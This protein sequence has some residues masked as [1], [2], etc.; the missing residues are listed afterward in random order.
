VVYYIWYLARTSSML[1]TDIQS[2]AHMAAISK[3]SVNGFNPI[4][5]NMYAFS[6]AKG[7]LFQR[8]DNLILE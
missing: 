2:Y 7:L 5:V 8:R 3:H 4:L 1:G 6:Q